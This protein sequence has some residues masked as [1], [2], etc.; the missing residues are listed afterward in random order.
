MSKPT[1][2]KLIHKGIKE[3][4]EFKVEHAEKILNMNNNGG[5]EIADSKFILDENGNIK[6]KPKG[7]SQDGD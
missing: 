2:I 4:V 3:P 6:R 5:W 1:K 7:S